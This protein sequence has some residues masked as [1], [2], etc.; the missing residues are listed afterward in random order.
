MV[1]WF[2]KEALFADEYNLLEASS[3]KTKAMRK[4]QVASIEELNE[5]GLKSLVLEAVTV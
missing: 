3:E 1:I 5:A 2:H 4:Y